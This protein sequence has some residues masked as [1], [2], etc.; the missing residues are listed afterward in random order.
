MSADFPFDAN[1]K[2]R[3]NDKLTLLKLILVDQSK[4][5]LTVH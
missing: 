5:T 1:V 3:Y 4:N 2:Q